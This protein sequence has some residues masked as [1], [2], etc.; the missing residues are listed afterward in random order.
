M[1]S[2]SKLHSNPV[3]P[4]YIAVQDSLL[5]EDLYSIKARMRQM[6]HTGNSGPVAQLSDFPNLP[7]YYISPEPEDVPSRVFSGRQSQQSPTITIN[8]NPQTN[9]APP[10]ISSASPL[11]ISADFVTEHGHEIPVHDN[12]PDPSRG[13]SPTISSAM[14]RKLAGGEVSNGRS[15]ALAR[16]YLKGTEIDSVR[17][18]DPYGS[19]TSGTASRD[20]GNHIPF[21]QR[22]DIYLPETPREGGGWDFDEPDRNSYLTNKGP[23]SNG[24]AGGQFKYN[25]APE[26]EAE[27]F[28]LGIVWVLKANRLLVAGF[29]PRSSAP[30]IGVRTGDILKSVDDV[31]VLDLEADEWGR[32][33]AGRLMV[34]GQHS[35]CRLKLLRVAR[36][37]DKSRLCVIDVTLPRAI[38]VHDL[39]VQSY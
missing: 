39:N 25:E 23:L 31:D 34:G 32:H 17:L 9:T 4:G 12:Q 18:F 37:G 6:G 19:Q 20:S 8:L 10:G 2:Q 5:P 35:R 15:D 27:K 36:D 1:R 21:N 13:R 26:E 28:S 11:M 24:S 33:E 22:T 29:N 16:P 7:Q 3:S 38:S 30:A 14:L